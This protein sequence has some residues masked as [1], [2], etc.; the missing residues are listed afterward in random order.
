MD[1]N[2]DSPIVGADVYSDVVETQTFFIPEDPA[3][4]GLFWVFHPTMT[5]PEDVGFTASKDLY[6]SDN[7]TVSIYTI[8][9]LL[10]PVLQIN[11]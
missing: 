5:D 4:E 1:D 2:D 11:L 7:A 10:L 3:S 6:G 9:H 8:N